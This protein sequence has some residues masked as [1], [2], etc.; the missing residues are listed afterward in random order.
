MWHRHAVCTRDSRSHA[1]T[2]TDYWGQREWEPVRY[3]LAYA[4]IK[5]L[6]C[7]VGFLEICTPA[8]PGAKS[9]EDDGRR[10]G[11]ERDLPSS[12]RRTTIIQ[13]G[14]LQVRDNDKQKLKDRDDLPLEDTLTTRLS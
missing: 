7:L 8:S 9:N 14:Q 10:E 6:A 12:T 3:N 4:R 11:G 1:G 13:E 5:C 2:L